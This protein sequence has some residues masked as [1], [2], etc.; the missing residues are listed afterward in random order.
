[1]FYASQQ[2]GIETE[3]R[4]EDCLQRAFMVLEDP[5]GSRWVSHSRTHLLAFS[6]QTEKSTQNR[7]KMNY[8]PDS[9]HAV[10]TEAISHLIPSSPN[11]WHIASFTVSN[12]KMPELEVNRCCHTSDLPKLDSSQWWS[13]N[14]NQRPQIPSAEFGPL[15]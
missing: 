9:G 4:M 13:R 6:S 11:S 15:W 5:T 7:V 10:L 14:Q 12:N 8:L 3:C 1:M 2:P